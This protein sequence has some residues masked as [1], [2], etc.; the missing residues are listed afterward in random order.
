MER[1]SNSIQHPS[2]NIYFNVF[3]SFEELLGIQ[4]S[5]SLNQTQSPNSNKTKSFTSD[6]NIRT[7]GSAEESLYKNESLVG[8]YLN[9]EY[10]ALRV[11][12]L[13]SRFDVADNS[14]NFLGADYIKRSPVVVSDYTENPDKYI[15]DQSFNHFWDKNGIMTSHSDFC[16][17]DYLDPLTHGNPF[18]NFQLGDDFHHFNSHPVPKS[19]LFDDSLYKDYRIVENV[20]PSFEPVLHEG[21]YPYPLDQCNSSPELFPKISVSNKATVFNDRADSLRFKERRSFDS[22]GSAYGSGL[23][24]K[25]SLGVN[26]E[27]FPQQT[28]SGQNKYRS[29]FRNNSLDSHTLQTMSNTAIY[30][31]MSLEQFTENILSGCTQNL[32]DNQYFQRRSSVNSP[33]GFKK[34]LGRK[35]NLKNGYIKKPGLLSLSTTS[36]SLFKRRT[37]VVHRKLIKAMYDIKKRII[38]EFNSSVYLNIKP[39]SKTMDFYQLNSW[40]IPKCC[41]Y[42]NRSQIGFTNPEESLSRN[43]LESEISIVG[44]NAYWYD[45]LKTCDMSDLI[46]Q[47]FTRVIADHVL[48][49]LKPFEIPDLIYKPVSL[50]GDDNYIY[51][52]PESSN[53]DLLKDFIFYSNQGIK[54]TLED[55]LKG[56]FFEKYLIQNNFFLRKKSEFGNFQGRSKGENKKGILGT[57]YVVSR[58]ISKKIKKTRAIK[59]VISTKSCIANGIKTTN[60][61]SA[62]NDIGGNNR[63]ENGSLLKEMDSNGVFCNSVD[64]DCK[65]PSKKKLQFV[66]V[67]KEAANEA[68][69]Y[70]SEKTMLYV[71]YNRSDEPSERRNL[72]SRITNIP[73]KMP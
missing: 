49:S 63:C 29:Y 39:V 9:T 48:P 70:N 27:F 54:N 69:K 8:N 30:Q 42:T 46:K 37:N 71:H 14:E 7:I 56:R 45:L 44:K 68:A 59:F 52:L 61:C 66:Y 28:L 36:K 15:T 21:N 34:E 50:F 4:S 31:D 23:A 2:E 60:N 6:A 47:D 65:K 18:T 33:N 38:M 62:A 67:Q 40:S 53:S 58:K 19:N 51:I 72:K 22:G 64:T 57:K 12:G 17:P 11:D 16:I 35:S 41:I 25:K 13:C 3:D 1:K 73:S 32:Q 26:S 5:V 24:L 10:E 20:F 55:E 43:K